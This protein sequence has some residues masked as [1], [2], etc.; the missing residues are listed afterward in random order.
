MMLKYWLFHLLFQAV[1]NVALP[2]P[3]LN[4]TNS[5]SSLSSVLTPPANLSECL[6]SNYCNNGICVLIR[7]PIPRVSCTCDKPFVDSEA[8][9]C[10]IKGKSRRDAFTIRCFPVPFNCITYM[11]SLNFAACFLE[12]WV[13]T[14]FS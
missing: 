14:G 11:C 2:L 5:S 9:L 1:F 3:I 7:D 13:E 10:T 8:G 12:C 6:K 4:S